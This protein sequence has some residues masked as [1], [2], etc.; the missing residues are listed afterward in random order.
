MQNF[1]PDLVSNPGV[2]AVAGMAGI[3]ASTVRAPLTGLVL[4]VEMTSNYE[5]ILPLIMTTVIASAFTAKLGNEPIYTSLL[6]ISAFTWFSPI[7]SAWF[8]CR[9]GDRRSWVNHQPSIV[10]RQ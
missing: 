9:S 10:N 7:P 3:F 8:Q 5:M 2:F 6:E 4:A 1:F